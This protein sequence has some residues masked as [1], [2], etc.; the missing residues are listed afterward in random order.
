MQPSRNGGSSG[1]LSCC[2]QPSLL[3]PSFSLPA[4][5]LNPVLPFPL[6]GPIRWSAPS[7][8]RSVFPGSSG[9]RW[10]SHA[11]ASGFTFQML[12]SNPLVELYLGVS[13]SVWCRPDDCTGYGN[14]VQSASATS[15]ALPPYWLPI[16]CPSVFASEVHCCV[17]Y[18]AVSQSRPS[19][20]APWAWSRL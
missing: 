4:D 7:C 17:W 20:P 8:F 11:G 9:P 10:R 16:S 15:S 1:C 3:P 13:C 12:F 18:S 14:S 5:I 2:W 19:T 6:I